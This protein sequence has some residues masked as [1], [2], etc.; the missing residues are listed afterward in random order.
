MKRQKKPPADEPAKPSAGG[1]DWLLGFLLVAA[2]IIAYQP[3]WH[4]GMIWDDDRHITPPE[5]RSFHGLARIWTE[6]GATQQYYPLVH[7][8]FWLEHR[9]WGGATEGYHWVNILLHAFSALLGSSTF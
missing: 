2:T 8:V 3:A 6:L 5:L 1:R 7:S 9:L 4:A